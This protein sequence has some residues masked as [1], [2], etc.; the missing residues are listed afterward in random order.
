M[1]HPNQNSIDDLKAALANP[2]PKTAKV[3][4]PK[5]PKPTKR[6]EK[7]AKAKKDTSGPCGCGC[8]GTAKGGGFLPGHDSRLAGAIKRVIAGKPYEGERAS[9]IKASKSAHPA[10]NT[11]HFHHLF[12]QLKKASA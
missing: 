6:A 10:L 11:P 8:D 4:K 1:D 5:A 9:V 7:V 12:D 2:K 3:K